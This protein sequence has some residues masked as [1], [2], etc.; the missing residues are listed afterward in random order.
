MGKSILIQF[1]GQSQTVPFENWITVEDAVAVAFRHAGWNKGTPPEGW[2]FTLATME[3]KTLEV[4]DPKTDLNA[5]FVVIVRRPP[6]PVTVKIQLLAADAEKLA[7]SLKEGGLIVSLSLGVPAVLVST[8][9][10]ALAA[11]FTA[12]WAAMTEQVKTLLL[13]GNKF[14]IQCGP[15]SASVKVRRRRPKS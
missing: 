10:E 13:G 15:F 3:G 1:E 14:T 7:G 8:D 2:R 5:N 6:V 11:C 4:V 12:I 9:E